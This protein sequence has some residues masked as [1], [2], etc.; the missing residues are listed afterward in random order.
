MSMLQFANGNGRFD[1]RKRYMAEIMDEQ[2]N[3]KNDANS[4]EQKAKV[5]YDAAFKVLS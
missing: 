4:P 2:K 5:A 1:S 3:D